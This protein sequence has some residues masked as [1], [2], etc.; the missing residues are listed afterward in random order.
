MKEI[1]Y[2]GQKTKVAALFL[3]SIEGED[4]LSWQ[5]LQKLSDGVSILGQ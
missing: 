5:I 3:L 2:Q 4:L 1:E